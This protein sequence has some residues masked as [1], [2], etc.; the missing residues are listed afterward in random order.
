MVGQ[1]YERT[2]TREIGAMRGLA[3]QMP[4]IGA[5][6]VFAGIASLGLPTLAG[7]VAEITI[8]LGAFDAFEGPTSVAILGV[9]L[10][11]GYILW[12]LQRSMF[13]P[14]DRAW[15]HLE[16]ARHWW[17]LAPVAALAVTSISM[18]A[19]G[20]NS[21]LTGTV[22]TTGLCVPNTSAR[23]AAASA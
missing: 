2:H 5:A 6:L 16:D 8:F 7:F 19:S 21:A 1:V 11:A 20:R 9:L 15:D 4:L 14:R 12:V 13:G 3:H 17:E 10:A 23:T 18:N 22:F